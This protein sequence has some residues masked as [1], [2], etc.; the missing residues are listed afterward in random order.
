VGDQQRERAG[1]LRS[2]VNEVD[3]QAVDR[4]GELFETVQ[5]PLLRPPVEPIAP[6]REELLQ[7]RHVRA[8]R[9]AVAAL[10]CLWYARIPQSGFQIGEHRIRHMDRE[11]TNRGAGGRHRLR[12]AD[13]RNRREQA[14]EN[15]LPDVSRHGAGL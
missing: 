11:R 5:R 8:V 7:V 9:P 13:V 6:V 1:L 10:Q 3:R 14:G 12:A 15:N 2:P 4:G